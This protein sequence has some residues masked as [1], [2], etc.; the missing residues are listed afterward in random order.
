MIDR[1]KVDHK[2]KLFGEAIAIF[3]LYSLSVAR[4]LFELLAPNAEFFVFKRASR[5]EICI[6]IFALSFIIPAFLVLIRFV[7]EKISKKAA[8][9][10]QGIVIA[11]LT[12][13]FILPGLNREH[14]ITNNSIMI[15]L[16][17]CCVL[18]GVGY[19]LFSWLR[20]FYLYLAPAI[21]IVPLIFLFSPRI[22]RMLFTKS[23]EIHSVKIQSKTPLIFI[24]F[25]EFPTISL[26]D[27]HRQIDAVRYPNFALMS[28]EWNWYRE[29]SSVAERTEG[30]VPA[31]LSGSYPEKGSLPTLND[32][33]QNLFTLLKSSHQL[34]IFESVTWLNPETSQTNK[35][36]ENHAGWKS[37]FSDLWLVY[38]HIILPEKFLFNLPPV[39]QAWGDFEV[40]SPKGVEQRESFKKNPE[41]VA[42]EFLK[43]IKPSDKPVLYFLHVILPHSPWHLLPSGKDYESRSLEGIVL[44]YFRLSKDESAVQRAYQRHLLQVGFVDHWMGNLIKRLKETDLYDRSVIV[45]VGDHG[46]SFAPG[47][48]LRA[49]SNENREEI[50]FVPLFIKAPGQRNGQII[51]WNVEIIDI[52]P[53]IAELMQFKIPWKVDGVSVV[54]N[55]PP[56]GRRRQFCDLLCQNRFYF[57]S[58]LNA[59]GPALD[60]KL[61]WFGTGNHNK[62][63]QFGPCNE[64]IGTNVSNSPPINSTM[65]IKLRNPDLFVNV[66]PASNTI[67][68]FVAGTITS[69]SS[70]QQKLMLGI[71]MNGVFQSTTYSSVV[72]EKLHGFDSML[73]ESVVRAGNNHLQI[74]EIPSCS[75]PPRLL[76][77][78]RSSQ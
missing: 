37:Y 61:K 22:Q 4:P 50:M 34:E 7:L 43:L 11:A 10:F 55:S 58:T 68:T 70:L 46:I 2:K 41:I 63:F 19:F 56:A 45:V 14:F 76:E 53:T 5:L 78:D 38:L 60:R 9:L 52:L 30:A 29:T 66:T 33:P 77:E 6:F 25:D 20:L 18:L 62:L 35:V 57:E 21:I 40:N 74:F 12:L 48:T 23:A 67:P 15:M 75:E 69:N 3:A 28:K 44:H 51:D 39:A 54:K 59:E 8:N 49:L 65:K 64:L 27:E 13:A 73:P 24:V 71:A 16:I 26:M 1:K 47:G 17:V 42:D 72:N 32:Y 31:I 36:G